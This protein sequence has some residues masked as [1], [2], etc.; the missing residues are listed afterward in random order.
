VADGDRDRWLCE[1][2][3]RTKGWAGPARPR[4][5]PRPLRFPWRYTFSG[6]GNGNRRLIGGA[7]TIQTSRRRG[8]E[9]G[10]I[11][12]TSASVL[13]SLP[14]ICGIGLGFLMGRFG[15]CKRK[16]FWCDFRFNYV[17]YWNVG[18][19]VCVFFVYSQLK[20]GPD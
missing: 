7:A 4:N 13:R 1:A 15:H 9:E 6:D 11:C 20:H 17:L 10:N 19:Y 12:S 16:V 5:S 3:H 18:L 8:V 14:S 2:R